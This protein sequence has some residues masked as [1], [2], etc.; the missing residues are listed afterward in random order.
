MSRL[1][2][3][4]EEGQISTLLYC[5]SKY[6]NDVLTSTNISEESKKKHTAILV[7]FDT[8]FKVRKNV[9]SECPQFNH[10]V[11]EQEESVKQFITSLYSFSENCQYGELK[12]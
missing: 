8:N 5:L 3:E 12:D 9:I 7:K 11:Q 4:D 2:K 1:S 10:R 6:A